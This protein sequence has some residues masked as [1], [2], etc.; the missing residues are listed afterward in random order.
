MIGLDLAGRVA[1]R[2]CHHARLFS[3]RHH[4]RAVTE[5][6]VGETPNFRGMVMER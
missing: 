1:V 6:A 2:M 4:S 5:T 3:K